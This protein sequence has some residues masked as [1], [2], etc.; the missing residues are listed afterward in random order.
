MAAFFDRNSINNFIAQFVADFDELAVIE[1][2][3]FLQMISHR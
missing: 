2:L 3:Y 1:M